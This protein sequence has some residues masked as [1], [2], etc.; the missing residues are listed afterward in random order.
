MPSHQAANL[1]A[2]RGGPVTAQFST[3][4]MPISSGLPSTFVTA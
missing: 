4:A 1:I 2:E 3:F